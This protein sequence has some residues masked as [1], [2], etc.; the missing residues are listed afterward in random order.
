MG[1]NLQHLSWEEVEDLREKAK[2]V[3][4]VPVGSVEQHGRH[5]PCGTD[6]LS[7]IGV[8]DDVAKRVKALVVPP[9]W[10][11]WSPHH[12]AYPGTITLRPEVLIE[13]VL[14]V[15]KSLAHHGF[16]RII[17]ING[18]RVANVPPLQQAAWKVREATDANIVLVDLDSMGDTVRRELNLASFGHCDEF[19]TSHL[20]YLHPDLVKEDR[21]SKYTPKPKRFHVWDSQIPGDK[22]TWVP[23]KP[24]A[25]EEYERLREVSGGV[26][27]DPTASTREKGR[28]IHEALVKNIA[29]LIEDMRKS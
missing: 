18:H 21:I 29:E 7:A 2:G 20:L 27:S 1:Y 14:D 15:C 11:G 6:S 22:I 10:F 24:P 23:S 26:H 5:L 25:G 12:M 19:E 13:L 9:L 17:I 3:A 4:I 16:K 28:R 8:A